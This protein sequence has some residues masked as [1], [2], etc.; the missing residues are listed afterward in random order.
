MNNDSA[1]PSDRLYQAPI[2]VGNS[3]LF[4]ERRALG[5]IAGAPNHKSRLHPDVIC[6]ITCEGDFEG[7]E[8]MLLPLF[9]QQSHAAGRVSLF[10]LF[11]FC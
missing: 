11:C 1:E 8:S 9:R 5:P 4:K 10:S 6:Y 2:V 3:S 7:L